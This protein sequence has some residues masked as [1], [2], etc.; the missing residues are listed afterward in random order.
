MK[1]KEVCEKTGLNDKTIRYYIRSGLIFPKY[2]ENYTGRKNF[3]FAETDIERLNQVAVLRKYSF[4]IN[5]IK[6]MLDDNNCIDTVIKE[7][8]HNMKEETQNSVKLLSKLDEISDCRFSDISAL[9]DFLNKEKSLPVSVPTDDSK[10]P[11]KLLYSK[12]KKLNIILIA[13]IIITVI[14]SAVTIF[15]L[16]DS[17]KNIVEWSSSDVNND[18]LII[19]NEHYE[20][21]DNHWTPY[22]DAYFNGE[23]YLFKND[24]KTLFAKAEESSLFEPIIYH[25][26]SDVYPDISI[27]DRV[28][29]ITLQ[30]DDTQIELNSDIAQLLANELNAD[31]T[32]IE[33][34]T[35][36][37]STAEVYVNVYY[38][39][40]PAYQN[41]F[42][43][44]YSNDNQLGVMYCETER[45]T[46]KF[47]K[48][49]M[50]LFSNKELI[51][52]IK[53]LNL[54]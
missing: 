10:K 3:D 38:K 20:I 29:K 26:S 28:E 45:N 52:Y 25:N 21:A 49:N 18:V 35:A 37:I 48:D 11:Y 6:S 23:Y 15:D 2:N 53:S 7:H 14:A 12:N 31:S 30:L 34:A 43:L 54:L 24:S 1:I 46:N 22:G 32:E 40:Y 8:I 51:S 36:D 13:V 39:N 44:C 16:Y 47:G 27:T 42:V 41:D 33:T 19:D 17:V 50:V 5:D 9:C 4:S